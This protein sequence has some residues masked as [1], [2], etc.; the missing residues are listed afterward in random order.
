M[1]YWFIHI[2]ESKINHKMKTLLSVL[3]LVSIQFSFA[4]IQNQPPGKIA[5]VIGVI[6]Y[7]AVAPLKNCLNDAN[8]FAKKLKD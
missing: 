4:Q 3:L 6:N 8:G 7:E 2:N 5:V 1:F